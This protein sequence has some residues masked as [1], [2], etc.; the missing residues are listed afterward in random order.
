MVVFYE[1]KQG[2]SSRYCAR[3]FNPNTNINTNINYLPHTPYRELSIQACR[4]DRRK[5]A[6]Q[7]IILNCMVTNILYR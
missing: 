5:H 3:L 7:Y 1:G 6:I 2:A 4:T